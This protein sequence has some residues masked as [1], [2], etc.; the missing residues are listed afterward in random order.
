MRGPPA[1]AS[2]MT[3]TFSLLFRSSGTSLTIG[4]KLP[5]QKR[6]FHGGAGAGTEML[7]GHGDGFL[8]DGR[9]GARFDSVGWSNNYKLLIN[10]GVMIGSGED[11]IFISPTPLPSPSCQ[12]VW[13]VSVLPDRLATRPV[14]RKYRRPSA[15][16]SHQTR[17]FIFRGCSKRANPLITREFPP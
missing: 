15:D 11:L 7:G 6:A 9:V 4:I 10:Q 12:Q 14:A 3:P 8:R 2:A 1:T 13:P 17:G 16:G 5:D